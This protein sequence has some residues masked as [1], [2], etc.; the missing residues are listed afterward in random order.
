MAKKISEFRNVLSDNIGEDDIVTGLHE[1]DNANFKL[2]QIKDYVFSSIQGKINELINEALNNTNF[3]LS[4]EEVTNLINTALQEQG[5]GGGGQQGGEGGLSESEINNLIDNRLKEATSKNQKKYIIRTTSDEK[6]KKYNIIKNVSILKETSNGE[7]T[8][9]TN[10]SYTLVTITKKGNI[11]NFYIR[12]TNFGTFNLKS[13]SS[14]YIDIEFN[15]LFGDTIYEFFPSNKSFAPYDP[16]QVMI[17]LTDLKFKPTNVFEYAEKPVI[18]TYSDSQMQL[19]TKLQNDIQFIK[20]YYTGL[21]QPQDKQNVIRFTVINMLAEDFIPPNVFGTNSIGFYELYFRGTYRNDYT[22][23]NNMSIKLNAKDFTNI[24]NENE[25][26][27]SIF[28]ATSDWGT[29]LGGVPAG[30]YR[31]TQPSGYG[32]IIPDNWIIGKSLN[33]CILNN[34][35]ITIQNITKVNEDFFD[36]NASTMGTGYKMDRPEDYSL[37][38]IEVL[39]VDY[40]EPDSN[41][42]IMRLTQS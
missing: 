6:E 42:I 22:T 1:D 24:I 20:L 23:N 15:E 32:V 3:G 18:K 2:T 13:Y 27:V 7:F 16:D 33:S 40:I 35:S 10:F 21:N 38:Y 37:Y 30:T 14:M 12:L 8:S 36:T 25:I 17:E 5:T 11:S 26:D 34:T 28:Y 19:L 4:E 41:T 29:D 9:D 31:P 39:P